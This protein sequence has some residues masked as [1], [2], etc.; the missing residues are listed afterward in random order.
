MVL[1]RPNT[2][3]LDGLPMGDIVNQHPFRRAVLPFEPSFV[4]KRFVVRGDTQTFVLE[5]RPPYSAPVFVRGAASAGML[6]FGFAQ[7][8]SAGWFFVL[9][10]ALLSVLTLNLFRQAFVRTRLEFDRQTVRIVRRQLF[11]NTDVKIPLRSFRI[12]AIDQL[13]SDTDRVPVHYLSVV[14]NDVP[15]SLFVGYGRK[16]LAWIHNVITEWLAR[17][18]AV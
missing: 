12:V 1:Q 13:Y 3:A 15:D 9:G 4:P 10:G 2:R 17:R 6:T 8:W 16:D 18:D 11:A 7:G 5:G 14:A